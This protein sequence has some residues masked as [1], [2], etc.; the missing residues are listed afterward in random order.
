M[1]GW[2]YRPLAAHKS[3]DVSPYLND[4]VI[5]VWQLLTGVRTRREQE[6]ARER[7]RDIVPYL[8]T[9]RPVRA[10]DLANGRLRPQY[11][12]LKAA[13]HP[14]V[15]ID[16]L[17][18][19]S[20]SWADRGYRIARW[21]YSCHIQPW[22]KSWPGDRLACGDVS[23]LPFAD[24]TFDLVTSI[25]AFEHFLDVP[26]VVAELRRVMRPGGVAWVWIHVYTSLSGGHNISFT[27]IPLQTLPKGAE[28]WDH[29]AKTPPAG[30]SSLERV[31]HPTIRRSVRPAF[32]NCRA[33]LRHA[34]GRAPVDARDRG[35]AGRV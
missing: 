13:G 6:V 21:L 3:Y 27:E 7:Q 17:N 14:V 10:L 12:L 30:V 2:F 24:N 1:T 33:A 35:R 28:A 34:R 32:S 19:P 11:L 4:Y 29:L 8:D 15:G 16:L 20:S 26:A 25:A 31:A 5:S 18:R 22:A 9:S 23:T